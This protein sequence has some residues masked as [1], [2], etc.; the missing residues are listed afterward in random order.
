MLYKFKSLALALREIGTGA[1]KDGR[2][3]RIGFRIRRRGG[4]SKNKKNKNG[5]IAGAREG[6]REGSKR[7]T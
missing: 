6:T 4:I 3:R 2:T 1:R 5:K 7:S